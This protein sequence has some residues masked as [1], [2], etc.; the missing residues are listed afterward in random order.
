M[1]AFAACLFFNLFVGLVIC[2]QQAKL[3]WDR[4]RYGFKVVERIVADS[5]KSNTHGSPPKAS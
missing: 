2:L 4:K 1:Y 3:S 5:R